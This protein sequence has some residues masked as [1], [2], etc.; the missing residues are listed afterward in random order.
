VFLLYV[1]LGHGLLP[2]GAMAPY[3]LDMRSRVR[4]SDARLPSKDV[5]A[6]YAVSRTW[7]DRVKQPRRGRRAISRGHNANLNR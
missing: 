1:V 7:V 2:V 6:K 5:A 4:D 3:S